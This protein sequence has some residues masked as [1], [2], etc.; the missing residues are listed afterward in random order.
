MKSTICQF[1]RNV[2]Q[3]LTL[4]LAARGKCLTNGR[5]KISQYFD[6]KYHGT[7]SCHL[8]KQHIIKRGIHK[9]PLLGDEQ[10]LLCF[11]I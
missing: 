5:N 3:I 9:Q 4:I 2:T 7:Q 6:C 1:K 10:D 8:D 11:Y